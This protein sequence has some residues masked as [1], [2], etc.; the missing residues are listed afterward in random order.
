MKIRALALM[1][2]TVLLASC[3]TKTEKQTTTTTDTQSGSAATT[4]AAPASTGG[5]ADTLVIQEASDIPTMD[6]G[7]SYDSAS[8]SLLENVYETL[9][10]YKGSS[11]SELQGQLATEWQASDD[12]LTYRFT[13]R[14]DVK[15]HSGNPFTC[16]DAEYTFQRNLVTNTGDS[17][18]W[19]ISESLLGTP[20]NANDDSS[21]TWAKIDGAVQCD[22]ETL[23]FTLPKA[24]PAFVSKLAYLGQAIVDSKHAQAVGEWDGTEKTW[25][26]NVGKDLTGSPLAQKP[27]GTGP[28]QM[29]SKDATGYIFKAFDGYWGGAPAIKNVVR[30]I[31]P[32]QA[33]RLQALQAGDADIVETGGREIIEN[34]L[35]GQPGITVLDNLPNVAVT[36][37]TLN[38]KIAEGNP[39]GQ[40][41]EQSIPSDFFADADVRRAFVNAFDYQTFIDQVQM[42]KGELLN[43]ALPKSFMGYDPALEPQATNVEAA[44]EAF[45]KAFGGKLWDTGF[46]VEMNYREGS[47]PMQTALEMFKTNIESINPKFHV[48]LVGKQWSEILDAGRSGKLAMMEAGWSPDYAD[49][50]NFITTFYASNGFYKPRSNINDPELDKMISEARSVTDEAKRKEL[51]AQIARRAQDQAYYILLPSAV[52]VRAVNSKL[53]GFTAENF[54]PLYGGDVLWKSM[55]KN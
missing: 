45:K 21:V 55:T 49:P 52:Q 14:P 30:Q 24:D 7:T 20:A 4:P 40:L 28:Y 10:T 35:S 38:Q 6:P 18:N 43:V 50:D 13:L 37:I 34:Q 41:N 2:L 33:S 32:E 44:T 47:I 53:Q 8:S 17:G 12:G 15:F 11:I 22:G 1:T 25:K 5:K 54:N 42:G 27:S 26:E 23:V 51:Y 9:V 48:N 29:V 16:A 36:A 39:A 46:T 19:F 3:S 31:V